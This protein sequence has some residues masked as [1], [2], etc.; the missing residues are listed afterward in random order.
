MTRQASICYYLS[1]AVITILAAVFLIMT[2]VFYAQGKQK[3]KSAIKKILFLI[4]LGYPSQS[5]QTGTLVGMCVCGLIFY[6]GIQLILIGLW[7]Q[8]YRR[9]NPKR[10][11]GRTNKHNE[12]SAHLKS[13]MEENESYGYPYQPPT[14]YTGYGEYSPGNYGDYSNGG[15]V[16]NANEQMLLQQPGAATGAAYYDPVTWPSNVQVETQPD[17]KFFQ[18]MDWAYGAQQQLELPSTALEYTTTLNDTTNI[19]PSNASTIVKCIVTFLF[20][21]Y[22]R[23]ISIN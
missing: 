18:P 21:K 2:G 4:V 1:L 22:L 10:I 6:L 17:P 8:K 13:S 9:E 12:S 5:S 7:H 16:S 19:E 11:I 15:Y 3:K 23:L 14:E 20:R